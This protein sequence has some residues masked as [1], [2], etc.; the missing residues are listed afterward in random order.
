MSFS[1]IMGLFGRPTTAAMRIVCA[2]LFVFVP[3]AAQPQCGQ[4]NRSIP[5]NLIYFID[6]SIVMIT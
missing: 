2:T 6:I 5:I 4:P 1:K 3:A